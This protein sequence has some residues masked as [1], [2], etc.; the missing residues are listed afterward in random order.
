MKNKATAAL[1]ALGMVVLILDSKTALRGAQEAI[2]LCLQTVIPV[3]LPFFVLSG[4]LSA[5]LAQIHIPC[6]GVWSRL[7]RI[8]IA[9]VPIVFVGFLGGYPVG[10]RNVAQAYHQGHLDKASSERMLA[11]CSNAGP[12]FLFGIGMGLFDSIGICCLVWGI[13]ILSA[14]IVAVLTPCKTTHSAGSST[15]RARTLPQALQLALHALANVCGWVVLFRV[16]LAI[17]ERWCLWAFSPEMGII[18]SGLLELT[19]GC[20]QLN[21]IANMGLRMTL[22]SGFLSFGGLCVAMQTVSVCEGLS[23]AWYLPG[24][25]CQGA[26]SVLLCIP[27]QLVFPPEQRNLCSIPQIVGCCTCCVCYHIY[28]KR[29]NLHKLCAIPQYERKKCSISKGVVV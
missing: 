19:N 26:I 5:G 21:Q 9:A 14:L 24:K 8:P 23:T 1:A 10:A 18:L 13:H 11:F 12:A 20:C 27:A 16:M 4:I 17:G 7:L 22:F 29:G 25:L 28:A 15:L 2:T 6:Q 3:L